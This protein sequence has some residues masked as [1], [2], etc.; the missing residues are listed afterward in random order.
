MTTPQIDIT[1]STPESEMVVLLLSLLYANGGEITLSYD[2][3]DA[4]EEASFN[5]HYLVA[6]RP[7]DDK[8]ELT[9]IAS[10]V[11]RELMN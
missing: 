2:E 8:E 11:H 4:F 9:I 7:D 10:P 5:T 1:D 3:L 6:I